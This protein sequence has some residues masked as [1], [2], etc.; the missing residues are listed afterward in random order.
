MSRFYVTGWL[1]HHA[2]TIAKQTEGLRSFY[3]EQP[4]RTY[5]ECLTVRKHT[6]LPFVLDESVTD[7]R[8]VVKAWQDGAA[9]IVNIKISKFGG[10]TRARQAIEFCVQAGVAMTIEDT[11]GGQY[12]I[13][14]TAFGSTALRAQH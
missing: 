7:M 5:E 13:G 4:C 12:C 11:W 6:S 8:S 9:D 3:M 14:S 2:L 1:T 10:I